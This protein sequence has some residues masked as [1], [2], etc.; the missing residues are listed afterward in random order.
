MR[1][2]GIVM[3]AAGLALCLRSAA[4]AEEPAWDARLTSISGDVRVSLSDAEEQGESAAEADTPLSAGDRVLTGPDG[5]AEIALESESLIELGP[6]SEFVVGSLDRT[7]SSFTLSFGH[8]IAKLRSLASFEGRLRVHTPSAVA[9]VRGTE[10]GVDVSEQEGT[11]IGVFD[12]GEVEVSSQGAEF[13]QTRLKAGEETEIVS[14]G[15]RIAPLRVRRLRRLERFRVGLNRLRGR[16]AFLR[17]HWRALPPARRQEIRRRLH[18]R[19]R[20]IRR[21]GPR[22][23]RRRRLQQRARRIERRSR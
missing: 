9:A 16:R 17:A 22:P 2:F 19:M 5:K 21:S 3:A 11:A 7:D 8:L 18:E 13:P 1:R 12:E 4:S 15:G 6:N 23:E 20:E 14:V 10:F